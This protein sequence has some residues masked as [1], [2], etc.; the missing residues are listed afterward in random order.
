[1]NEELNQEIEEL[2]N[3]ILEWSI[4]VC[5]Y[6]WTIPVWK[7]EKITK[8]SKI[9]KILEKTY[10]KWIIKWRQLELFNIK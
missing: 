7:S 6:F 1:M 10:K 9:Y 5:K 2:N 3:L 8:D 4:A